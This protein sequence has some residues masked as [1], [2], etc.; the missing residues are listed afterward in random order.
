MRVE[1]ELKRKRA[2]LFGEADQLAHRIETIKKQVSALDQVIAIYNPA[3]SAPSA[4]RAERKRSRQ[5]ADNELVQAKLEPLARS[6]VFPAPFQIMRRSGHEH[7]TT[8][9]R[10]HGPGAAARDRQPGRQERPSGKAVVL[11]E[12]RPCCPSRPQGRPSLAQWAGRSLGCDP[13][14]PAALGC[15]QTAQ[16]R[17][18]VWRQAPPG[19][20]SQQCRSRGRG[21]GRAVHPLQGNASDLRRRSGRP[22]PPPFP[23]CV[24]G[25]D[26]LDRCRRSP[27]LR[28]EP[29]LRPWIRRWVMRSPWPAERKPRGVPKR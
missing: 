4:A 10:L 8:W 24:P 26:R 1:E 15:R 16:V 27:P 21:V 20:T 5:V 6:T 22:T 23:W 18:I 13:V 29:V 11:T 12:S 25:R 9:L 28:L 2:E 19:V 3:H 7:L 17:C 14:P